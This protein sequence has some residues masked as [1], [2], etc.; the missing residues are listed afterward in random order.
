MRKA[1]CVFRLR[2]WTPLSSI[3]S[4]GCKADRRQSAFGPRADQ[5]SRVFL[6]KRSNLTKVRTSPG[7]QNRG[8]TQARCDLSGSRWRPFRFAR[9]QLIEFQG[10]LRNNQASLGGAINVFDTYAGGPLP[11]FL[12]IF[13]WGHNRVALLPI[14]GP[15]ETGVFRLLGP[16]PNAGPPMGEF[17]VL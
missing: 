2:G 15:P 10:R 3:L 5:Q 16:A 4:R 12:A 11:K 1:P 13:C 9:K 8:A 7:E 6:P 14:I 17:P